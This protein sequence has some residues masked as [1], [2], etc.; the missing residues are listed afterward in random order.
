[1]I[2]MLFLNKTFVDYYVVSKQK[3][4][5]EDYYVVSKQKIFVED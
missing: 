4:S 3:T 2:T 5:M 1:M